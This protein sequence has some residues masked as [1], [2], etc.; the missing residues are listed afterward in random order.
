M[1]FITKLPKTAKGFDDIWV[2]VDRLTESAHFLAIRQSSSVENL[3]DV[4]VWEIISRYGVPLSIV[5]D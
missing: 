5:F 4:Y 3:A 2:I 1:E